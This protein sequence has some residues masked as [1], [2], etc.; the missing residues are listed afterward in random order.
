MG[1]IN[2]C[3]YSLIFILMGNFRAEI[4]KFHSSFF[5]V[6]TPNATKYTTKL[7]KEDS[8]EQNRSSSLEK[9]CRIAGMEVGYSSSILISRR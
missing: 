5:H 3:D 1:L 9:K 8:T 6:I 4:L 2:F 7:D